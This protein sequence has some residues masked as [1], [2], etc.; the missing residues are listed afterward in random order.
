MLAKVDDVVNYPEIAIPLLF[1][2]WADHPEGFVDGALW[3][4]YIWEGYVMDIESYVDFD[5][6][7]SRA[8]FVPGVG[9]TINGMYA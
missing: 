3:E 1:R 5:R 2:E 9:C 6:E 7:M 4:R 8:V